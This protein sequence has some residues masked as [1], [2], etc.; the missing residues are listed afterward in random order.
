MVCG[1]SARRDAS[2]ARWLTNFECYTC[3]AETAAR[4]VTCACAVC[5][6]CGRTR[7]HSA[8]SRTDDVLFI[9]APAVWLRRSPDSAGGAVWRG[10]TRR[11]GEH[12]TSGRLRASASPFLPPRRPW[13]SR[14]ASRGWDACSKTT[15]STRSS[16][17]RSGSRTTARSARDRQA[18]AAKCFD[19]GPAGHMKATARTT[20][21][22]A[23]AVTSDQPTGRR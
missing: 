8:R 23:V 11:L 9:I 17:G 1:R 14:R 15:R 21:V 4:R 22:R 2:C 20:A 18:P 6:T 3:S 7:R 13:R 16:P 5:R 12:N 19:E 10:L